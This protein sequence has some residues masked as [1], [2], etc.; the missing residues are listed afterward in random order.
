MRS[1][2]SVM[3]PCFNSADTLALALGSLTAQAYS[4]WECIIV[5]DGSSDNPQ[6]VVCAFADER[7]RIFRL[8]RNMGRGVARQ[9][10]LNHCQG[11]YLAVLDA[12]DWIYPDKLSSQLEAFRH[13]SSLVAVSNGTAIV[14]ANNELT[15][16]R[17]REWERYGTRR[18]EPLNDL[19]LP[20]L[21]WASCMIRM[22]I[23]KSATFDPSLRRAQD[24]DYLLQV[25]SKGPF[26]CQP[27][28]SYVYREL[29]RDSVDNFIEG[30]RYTRQ[31][32]RK[33]RRSHPVK[34]RVNIMRCHLKS[35]F[36]R[37]TKILHMEERFVRRRSQTATAEQI[38]Q[39]KEA[40]NIVISA[41]PNDLL[42]ACQSSSTGH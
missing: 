16:I 33:Y 22:A 39:F 10:A 40:Y 1:L 6:D 9:V 17:L 28:I 8:E 34:S 31:M 38:Q 13:D 4:N 2:V 42:N 3:M 12:D 23:A 21:T 19:A 36:Y 35:S 41:V 15:G 11:D 30:F 27:R 26:L 37:A 18:F 29:G 25:L 14:N 5:D 24:T 32:F 7:I 20:Q